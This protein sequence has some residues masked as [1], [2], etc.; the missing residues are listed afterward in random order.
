MTTITRHLAALFL[1][2]A[3]AACAEQ[4]NA[5][6]VEPRSVGNVAM[7]GYDRPGGVDRYQWMGR[8]YTDETALHA[9][10]EAEM[11]AQIDAILAEEKPSDKTLRVVL[12]D[13][14]DNEQGVGR[15]YHRLDEW[16]LEALRRS[17][18]F[19]DFAVETTLLRETTPQGRDFVLYRSKSGWRLKD[20]QGRMLRLLVAPNAQ[21]F[22]EA[23]K[24]A[25]TELAGDMDYLSATMV[26][27]GVLYSYRG[28]EYT[29][30][31]GLRAA[32]ERQLAEDEKQVV[33]TTS[34]LAGT[35]LVVLPR[36]SR[37]F[38]AGL[39]N[40]ATWQNAV[41]GMDAFQRFLDRRAGAFLSR[42]G[43]F[44]NVRVVTADW[45]VPEQG[46]YD[47]VFWRQPGS[48]D[49]MM[50]PKDGVAFSDA[51]PIVAASFAEDLRAKL[52]QPR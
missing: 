41:P 17:G 7:L 13:A 46:N 16:R 28:K 44:R 10:L 12:P 40:D 38:T 21:S 5:P 2:A 39:E 11:N 52:T 51:M 36:D 45:A 27:G 23:V 33:A 30:V 6:V 34:V 14:D 49:W 35:A 48:H 9:A 32:F 47:W 24:K 25:M 42:S 43:L 4:P 26:D 20:S 1:A 31:R 8:F 50:R 22:V 29:G 18:L 19:A 37:G 15:F 3:L